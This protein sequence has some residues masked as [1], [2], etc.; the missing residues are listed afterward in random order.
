MFCK[1]GSYGYV[2]GPVFGQSFPPVDNS[3]KG[4]E[5]ERERGEGERGRGGE[6]ER[7]RGGEGERGRGRW[8]WRENR[9]S[10]TQKLTFHIGSGVL[11]HDSRMI[12]SIKAI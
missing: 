10:N 9:E 5:E 1:L 11:N 2:L 8:R 4:N 3:K 12:S 6:G 7:G